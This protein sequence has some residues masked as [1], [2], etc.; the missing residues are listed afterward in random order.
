M[1]SQRS[2]SLGFIGCACLLLLL[3]TG[4]I[5]RA[6][7]PVEVKIEWY[8]PNG[9]YDIPLTCFEVMREDP[10]I[11]CKKFSPVQLSQSAGLGS[12]SG[13]VMALA[14]GTGPDVFFMQIWQI[15]TFIEQGFLQPL[16]EF[17]GYDE[18]GDGYIDD[19]EAI[20][21]HWKTVPPLYR[22]V[23]TRNGHVYCI[24]ARYYANTA[25]A[26]RRDLVRE[27][28]LDPNAQP[29]DWEEFY[30]WMQKL[31]WPEKKVLGAP[32]PRGQR[33]LYYQWHNYILPW[34]WS[35]GGS[36]VMEGKTNPVTGKTHW[37]PKEEIEFIDPETGESL[38]SEPS[39]W[40]ATLDTPEMHATLEFLWRCFHQPWVRDPS[41]N[42]CM[43]LTPEDIE[44][45]SVR[46][47][48]GR[49]FKFNA[50]N[51]IHGVARAD[52]SL[53][54]NLQY[55]YLTRGEVASILVGIGY[56]IGERVRLKPSQIGFWAFP[57]RKAGGAPVISVDNHW[58]GMS[59]S[60]AGEKNRR[61]R[62]KV[63]KIISAI[64]GPL[65]KQIYIQ[66]AV[67]NGWA[68]FQNPADL[69][70]AGLEEYVDAVPAEWRQQYELI[71]QHVRLDPWN[72]NWLPVYNRILKEIV[73]RLA[74]DPNYD[75][76]SA[77]KE[78]DIQ[79]NTRIMVT[80]SDEKLKRKRPVAWAIIGAFLLVCAFLTR[81]G[82]K[83]AKIA[84]L[85][86]GTTDSAGGVYKRWLP[87]LFLAPALAALTVWFYLPMC[88][89]AIIAFK[90]YRIFGE[91]RWIGVD[92][93]IAMFLDPEFYTN[94]LATLRFLG[95]N[96]TIGFAAPIILALFLN[97]V[98]R[99]KQTFR[100]F[101]FL[102]QIS[103]PIVIALLW[104]ELY[105]PDKWGVVNR[106]VSGAAGFFGVTVK[107]QKWL[108]DPK[109]AM[110]AVV[111]TMIWMSVGL[112]SMLYLAALKLVPDD[113]Y[114][115]ADIDG[116]GLFAK[117][118]RI[119]LPH[120]YPLM[121]INFVGA[122]VGA[123]HNMENI[124]VMTGGGAGT[125]VLALSIWYEAFAYLKFGAATS[126]AWVLGIMVIGFTVWQ[127]RLLR[128]AEFRRAENV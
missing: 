110:M 38:R 60:L 100:M 122:F 75:W 97:E 106:I 40:K 118:R 3:V 81:R 108:E 111:F 62:K 53:D 6:G 61:K 105:A 36:V 109:W 52:P 107:A 123:M 45:G 17:V 22:K 74:A 29:R 37:Y 57:P 54:V 114:E 65:G 64:G 127:L 78:G 31:T 96:L 83:K 125:N 73:R 2:L 71:F 68:A 76:R 87:L 93:F 18:N 82:W 47:P 28:G 102:P 55:D 101:Y 21:D 92:N 46:R 112:A 13:K 4:A 24:P 115:A 35:A 30:Q 48:D 33:G 5:A 7:E 67:D 116:A 90:D 1:K 11:V 113:L 15:Q 63:W 59:S 34:L 99:F 42:T 27:A 94:L 49:E 126:M 124:F 41:D 20:W 9:R 88:R 91:S 51:I 69:V 85:A 39:K 66:Y 98:P 56:A 8:D 77:L 128:R 70:A 121:I 79:A 50:K 95:Y 14:T 10:D 25:H 119:T 120:L 43:D 12:D 44:R 103:S 16:D 84:R 32:V 58:I 23:V 86:R 89:G 26:Y 72:A 80:R 19:D 117:L 104:K